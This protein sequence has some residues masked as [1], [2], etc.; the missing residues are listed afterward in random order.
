[1]SAGTIRYHYGDTETYDLT[2]TDS[3]GTPIDL[4]GVDDVVVRACVRTGG[5]PVFEKRVG[6][7]VE[8]GVTQGTAT[9]TLEAAD[10]LDV[11]NAWATLLWDCSVEGGDGDATPLEGQ[12]RIVPTVAEAAS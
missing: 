2:I 8:L 12:L 3:D 10:F 7:G 6:D 5:D 1:M 9:L 4:E 11:D